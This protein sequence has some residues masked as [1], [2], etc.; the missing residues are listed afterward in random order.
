MPTPAQ[1]IA[2]GFGFWTQSPS[3]VHVPPEY[4]HKLFSPKYKTVESDESTSRSKSYPK[5]RHADTIALYGRS[6]QKGPRG[7][8][9]PGIGSHPNA[10]QVRR[11]TGTNLRHANIKGVGASKVTRRWRCGSLA[12]MFVPIM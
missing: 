11:I 7:A 5:A 3:E 6:G 1:E 4:R 9:C 12:E 10:T 2:G 8:D